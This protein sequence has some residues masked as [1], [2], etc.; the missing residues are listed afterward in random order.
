MSYFYLNM[1]YIKLYK[2]QI[3]LLILIIA[4]VYISSV[5]KGNIAKTTSVIAGILMIYAGI[6]F[7]LWIIKTP[8]KKDNDQIV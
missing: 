3:L 6:T 1:R 8:I 7:V 5:V 4:L 2:K